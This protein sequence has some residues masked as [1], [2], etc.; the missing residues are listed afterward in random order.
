MD[1]TEE[2]KRISF[3]SFFHITKKPQKTLKLWLIPG[4]KRFLEFKFFN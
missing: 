4:A 2:T 3:L 1:D